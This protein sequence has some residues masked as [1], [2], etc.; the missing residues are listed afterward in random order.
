MMGEAMEKLVVL[1]SASIVT[2]D[3]DARVFTDGALVIMGSEIK[4]IGKSKDVL[5]E[6]RKRASEVHDMSG[7]WILPGTAPLMLLLD[8]LAKKSRSV[9]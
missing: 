9:M 1:H 4:A 3:P 7:R 6:Y 8:I 5:D 2:M